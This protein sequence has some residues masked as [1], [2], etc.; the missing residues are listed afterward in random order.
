MSKKNVSNVIDFQEAKDR[1]TSAWKSKRI[2][3]IQN[4]F[5]RAMGW[6]Q[7]TAPK[8]KRQERVQKRQR[9]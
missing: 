2:K 5:E 7:E 9:R 4:R 1:L 3:D 6:E 8:T